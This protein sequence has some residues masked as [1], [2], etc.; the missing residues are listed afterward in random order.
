MK[1]SIFLGLAGIA[2]LDMQTL[3][4]D[5]ELYRDLASIS[6]ATNQAAT[7]IRQ[8]RSLTRPLPFS[9]RALDLNA[10]VQQFAHFIERLLGP[11]ITVCLALAP[12]LALVWG[13]SSLL[14]QVAWGH[15]AAFT[16]LVLQDLGLSPAE[17]GVWTGLLFTITIDPG[18]LPLQVAPTKLRATPDGALEI[19]GRARDL[20]LGGTSV[21][22]GG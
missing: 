16:P 4:P 21:A 12:N 3:A 15:L 14:E 17:V 10:L 13:D 20:T 11:N 5:N 7:L 1:L 19:S 8:L 6:H 18:S 9:P 2:A 22:A